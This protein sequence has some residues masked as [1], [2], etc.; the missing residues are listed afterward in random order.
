MDKIALIMAAGEGTRML[1]ETH[2]VLHKI[3]GETLLAHT[4]RS[5]EQVVTRCTVIVGY[6]KEK[7]V[8]Q[9]DGQADVVEQTPDGWGTG[10]A[11]RS[12]MPCLNGRDGQVIVTAADMPLVLPET[13]ARL[14]SEVEKGNACAMLTDYAESPFG[15]GR[16]LRKDGKICAIVEQRDLE[17]GE[18]SIREI[19]G[20]VY[21]FDIESLLSALPLLKN[22]NTANEYYLTDVIK[23]LYDANKSIVG[24]PVLE[25][26]ECRGINDR[27]QLMQAEREMRMRINTRHMRAG[28]TFIDPESAYVHP[29]VV[30]GADTVIHPGCT[31]EKDTT[32]GFGAVLRS[33]RIKNSHIGDGASVEQSVIV[34]STVEPGAR[35]GPFVYIKSGSVTA[36]RYE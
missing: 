5:L 4:L 30:I 27:V 14:M 15:Y 7:V 18:Q 31:L 9:I 23:I 34:D 6:G 12:A 2:K 26:S 25:K 22:D 35:I 21:C 17:P 33:S 1:S 32:V 20:S 29:D 36:G 13:Y 28:V 10:H 11:I 16:V 19:N 3:C 8:R 24:V